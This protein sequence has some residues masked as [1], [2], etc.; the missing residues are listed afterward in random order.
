MTMVDFVFGIIIIFMGCAF[1]GVSFSSVF[2]K[3]AAQLEGIYSLISF[4]GGQI[5][6]YRTPLDNILSSYRNKALDEC[7]LCRSILDLGFHN[8]IESC[9]GL[10]LS[11]EQTVALIEFFRLLGTF[12]GESAVRHCGYY[13]KIFLELSEKARKEA[14]EKS[15]LCRSIGV[16]AGIMVA[17]LFI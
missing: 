16:L 17:V 9:H 6:G 4:I 10:L 5:E 1:G 3:R 12:D 11:R 14:S 13:G 7:G 2:K 15:R 8:G